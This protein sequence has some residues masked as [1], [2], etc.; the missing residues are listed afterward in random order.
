M[1]VLLTGATGFIGRVLVAELIQHNF[2]ISIVVRQKSNL[3]PDKVKQ[4][5]LGNFE[6]NPGFSASLSE[7]DCV[8]HLVGKAHVIDK[9]KASVLE[10]FRKINTVVTL[11]LAKQA[12]SAG[13]KRFI[14]LSSIGVNGNQ[15]IKP[16]LEIDTP[17]P[18]EPYAISKYEAEQGL[19]NLAINSSLEVVIIRPPLV[20]G[21]NAPGNFGRLIQW[22]GA[23]IMFP[24]PLGAV[25]NARTLIAIDNLVSFIITCT[26]HPK[27][28]NEIFLISDDDI[29]STTQLLK[30]VAKA[31]NKKALLLPIPVSWMVFVAKLLGKEA[32]AVRLFSS[33]IVDSG[34]AKNLLNWH[35]VTTMDEQLCKIT[36]NEKSN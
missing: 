2:N 13:V 8:I 34:K 29:I 19:L 28:P 1:N 20:Y 15:N 36:A 23:K 14:F 22:A 27:A 35:P 31:F 4:F 16:F 32:D 30:K 17:N 18:Q 3:F 7:V 9:T 25:N 24:L 5:V 12:V 26:L 10:E 6:S 11:N 21:N 33:L